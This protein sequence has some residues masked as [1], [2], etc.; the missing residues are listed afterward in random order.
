LRLLLRR[1][2]RFE[3]RFEL[4]LERRLAER[5][6]SSAIA[7]ARRAALEVALAERAIVLLTDSLNVLTSEEGRA[8]LPEQ[9]GPVPPFTG[10]GEEAG[11]A[12]AAAARS[13]A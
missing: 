9:A 3:L 13:A 5:I 2:R 7:A 4:R 12:G 6:A 10:T 1:E 11:A 8:R